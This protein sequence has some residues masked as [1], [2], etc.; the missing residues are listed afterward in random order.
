MI[1]PF[2]I[3][4]EAPGGIDAIFALTEAAFAPM[5]FSDGSEPHII[6]ALRKDGDLTLSLVAED[7]G[8]IPNKGI[9][10]QITFSPVEID[11]LTNWYGLGPVSAAPHLQ[12]QGIGS[13]LIN[14]GLARL[15][16]MGGPNNS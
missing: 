16:E 14:T 2:T 11:G 6:N 9:I 12:K 3:R 8:E 4:D 5:P 7:N 10:G 13:A 15:K 1:P